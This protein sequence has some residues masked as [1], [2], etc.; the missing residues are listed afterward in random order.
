MGLYELLGVEKNT[1]MKEIKK[2]Y[3]KLSKKHHPDKGGDPKI[4]IKI[5]NAY[6]ILSDEKT[7]K[8]YD[9]TGDIPSDGIPLKT[10]ARNFLLGL[11]EQ[12]IDIDLVENPYY[13]IP[14]DIIKKI[15]N[16]IDN[17]KSHI[18]TAKKDIKQ[19]EEILSNLIYNGDDIDFLSLTLKHKIQNKKDLIKMH[20]D[21][22]EESEYAK[23]IISDYKYSQKYDDECDY[24]KK[25][26]GASLAETFRLT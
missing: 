3:Y 14:E 19:Y 24:A 13:K 15:D 21:K 9:E 16:F 22:I 23:E 8:K 4:F 20:N 11:W 25:T 18:K 7:R 1:T 5:Q 2:A 10:S 6:E 12:I 17:R 26:I